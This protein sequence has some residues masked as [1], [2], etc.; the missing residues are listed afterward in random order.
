MTPRRRT[1]VTD[2]IQEFPEMASF[3]AKAIKE[4]VGNCGPLTVQQRERLSK[5]A[6]K[7]EPDRSV[8][9]LGGKAELLST[10][11]VTVQRASV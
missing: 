6:Q 2:R 4:P 9:G 5:P 3:S 8:E 1:E 10:L 11:S 7:R